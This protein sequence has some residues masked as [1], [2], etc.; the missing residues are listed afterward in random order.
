MVQGVE[1]SRAMSLKLRSHRQSFVASA[2]QAV[3]SGSNFLFAVI[4]ARAMGP[5]EYGQFALVL[6]LWLLGLGLQR[7]VLVEPMT[8]GA[9]GLQGDMLVRY[10]AGRTRIAGFLAAIAGAAIL[11]AATALHLLGVISGTTAAVV[12]AL[13]V[14]FP[15]LLM[16]DFLRWRFMAAQA[17]EPALVN[18]VIFGVT[19]LVALSVIDRL[20]GL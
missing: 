13:G 9:A 6:A 16:Q 5:S 8:L 17:A 19:Q 12:Y 14:S 4:A 1:L 20:V 10:L 7:S 2:D 18:D 15:P 3:A 11:L